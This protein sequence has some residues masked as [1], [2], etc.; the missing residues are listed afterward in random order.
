M[1]K[2]N[3]FDLVEKEEDLACA[4]LL[5]S[6]IKDL[7]KDVDGVAKAFDANAENVRVLMSVLLYEKHMGREEEAKPQTKEITI[8]ETD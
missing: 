6:G 7:G 2:R 4:I 5:L 3:C 1:D 8:N